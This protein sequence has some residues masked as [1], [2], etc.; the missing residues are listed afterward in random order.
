M[1]ESRSGSQGSP[2][3]PPSEGRTPGDPP[4]ASR[5]GPQGSPTGP[6]SEGRT[7]GDRPTARGPRRQKPPNRGPAGLGT[8]VEARHKPGAEARPGSG[9]GA[10]IGNRAV[11]DGSRG[12]P[13]EGGIRVPERW[14]L[15][16]SSTGEAHRPGLG[17]EG[18]H[19]ETSGGRL[20]NWPRTTHKSREAGSMGTKS[21]GASGG[22]LGDQTT[23]RPTSTNMARRSE[24][25]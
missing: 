23:T 22:R 6:P 17:S 20:G 11:S 24:G 19:L 16:S 7:P 21:S 13:E 12:S 2:T 10:T 15:T 4:T 18:T 14:G 1:T 9:A 3:G 25:A 5:S 8:G